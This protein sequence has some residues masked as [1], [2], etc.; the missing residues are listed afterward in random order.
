MPRTAAAVDIFNGIAE[1]RRREIMNLQRTGKEHA[2]GNSW[3]ASSI[4]AGRKGAEALH[5][6]AK[7]YERY[8]THQLGLI[9][10]RAELK[11][12]NQLA[13]QLT[14]REEEE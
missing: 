12:A 3:S 14:K 9:K 6:W 5:D 1:L 4:P 11:M 2:V 13:K 8:L 7:T 10:Q